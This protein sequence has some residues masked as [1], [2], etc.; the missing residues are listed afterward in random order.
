VIIL[1][2]PIG[3]CTYKVRQTKIVLPTDTSGV[4]PT[5]T[6]MVTLT[7]C[8]PKGSA[9]KRITVRLEL[10]PK[11]TETIKGKGA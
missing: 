11:E 1:E 9:K 4:A 8:H 5:P 10:Q 7:S 2:T 3:S 6:P